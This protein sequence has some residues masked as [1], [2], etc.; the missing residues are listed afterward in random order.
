LT[1]HSKSGRSGFTESFGGYFQ[2]IRH[3]YYVIF[4]FLET[5][6]KIY[7]PNVKILWFKKYVRL[8]FP[9]E[10]RLQDEKEVFSDWRGGC[11][12]ESSG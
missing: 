10:V 2:I 9:K 7:L 12:A 4:E 6:V 3:I 1:M 8:R 5:S 11:G